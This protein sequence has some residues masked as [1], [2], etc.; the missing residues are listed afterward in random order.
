VTSAYV[1]A[2]VHI[3]NFKQYGGETKAS[4]NERARQ[5]LG[6]L[7]AAY[8]LLRRSDTFIVAGDLFDSDR[9]TPQMIAAAMEAGE[10][11]ADR[12]VFVLGNHDATAA[13]AAG[14]NAFAPFRS[15]ERNTI[16]DEAPVTVAVGEYRD[17]FDV[18]CVPFGFRVTD[19]A[20]SDY[21]RSSAP[22]VVV[23]HAGIKDSSTPSYLRSSEEAIDVDELAQW[24]QEHGVCAAVAG[25]WHTHR[26]WPKHNIFQVGALCPTGWQNPGLTEYGSVLK[27]TRDNGTVRVERLVVPG[28]RFIASSSEEE[29]RATIESLD[30]STNTLN[31]YVRASFPPSPTVW[32]T[33]VRIEYQDEV[34]TKQAGVT[35]TADSIREAST[36]VEAV[37]QYVQKEVNDEAKRLR[38]V[39]EITRRLGI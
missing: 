8:S 26:A 39:R 13:R 12:R 27:L 31:L 30:Y 7:E 15:Q 32:P 36:L 24:M 14:D 38:L 37:E 18:L 34:E 28:P 2:D 10:G 25:D 5:V 23:F 19:L 29:L 22:L 11:R 1:V 3:A 16:V 17:R 35:A 33:N 21:S 20:E 9:P 4:L 6:T